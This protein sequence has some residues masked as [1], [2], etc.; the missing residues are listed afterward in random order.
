MLQN[1]PL[2]RIS[3]PRLRSYLR[4]EEVRVL[5]PHDGLLI[6]RRLTLGVITPEYLAEVSGGLPGL[7]LRPI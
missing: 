2:T 5:L 3:S 6:L 1:S 7:L 4:F